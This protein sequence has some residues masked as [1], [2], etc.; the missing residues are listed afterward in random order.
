MTTQY[1]ALLSYWDRSGIIQAFGPYDTEAAA[2]A[3]RDQLQ[4]LPAIQ[5]GRWEIIPCMQTVTAS[6]SA[7]R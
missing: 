6:A 2:E 3:A 7:S 4:Q 5:G 1:I